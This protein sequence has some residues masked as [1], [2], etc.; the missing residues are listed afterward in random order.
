ML[1]DELANVLTDQTFLLFV[2]A[3][4]GCPLGLYRATAGRSAMPCSYS[5]VTLLARL[6]G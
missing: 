6:R 4:G 2:F 1:G 5:T 3:V